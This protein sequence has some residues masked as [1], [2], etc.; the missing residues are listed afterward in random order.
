MSTVDPKD[1]KDLALVDLEAELEG[2]ESKLVQLRFDH[3]TRGID[4]PMEIRVLRR[5]IARIQTELR[6]REIA[7]MDA[8]Q[9]A[10]RSKIVAR[11]SAK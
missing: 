6:A 7:A 5:N 8:S 4:S 9:L 2:T 1:Y 10:K 3:S 11:R